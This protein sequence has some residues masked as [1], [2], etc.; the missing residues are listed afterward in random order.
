MAAWESNASE[1]GF[2]IE[3]G[4]P[5]VPDRTEPP[6]RVAVSSPVSPGLVCVAT[7]SLAPPPRESGMC[8]CQACLVLPE[9]VDVWFD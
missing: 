1:D 4:T 7:I 5:E 9:S 3:A 8:R 6:S 2:D